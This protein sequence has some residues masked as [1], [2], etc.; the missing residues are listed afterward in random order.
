MVYLSAHGFGHIGQTA[1]VVQML[2]RRRP[3][4]CITVRS[5]APRFKL[6]ERFGNGV[7]FQFAHTDIG[8]LQASAL[9]VRV[10][11]TAAE[12]AKFHQNWTKEIDKE[13]GVLDAIGADMVLANVPYLPLAA[14]A[15]VGIPSIALGSLNW[16][17]I[18]RHYFAGHCAKTAAVVNQMREAY[19]GVARFLRTTP[20][21][22]M[23]HQKNIL[24]IG[25]IAQLGTDRKEDIQR[26]L[27]LAENVRLVLVSLGGMNLQVNTEYWPRFKKILFIVPE[28]WRS[29]HPDTVAF[30]LLDIPFT[31]LMVSCDALVAKPGYGSFVESACAGMPVLYL[32]RTNWPEAPHLISW[33]DE[34]GRLR[35]LEQSAL[36]NGDLTTSLETVWSQPPPPVVQPTGVEEAVEAIEASII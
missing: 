32:E 16:L 34:H 29:I 15:K 19:N 30:E 28:S 35:R 25:P 31:D 22:P 3:D 23:P 17:E 11:E 10:E 26:R 36:T 7:N 9:D 5:S 21:M 20:S 14:A 24:D 12:Y 8:M 27:G 18:Y 1:P 33:L 6:V 4:I 2:L 13:A